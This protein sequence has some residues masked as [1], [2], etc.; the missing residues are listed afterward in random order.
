MGTFLQTK[1]HQNDISWLSPE[2]IL[3][4]Q[5]EWRWDQMATFLPRSSMLKPQRVATSDVRAGPCQCS[6][7]Q[8]CCWNML[9]ETS[10]TTWLKDIIYKS[11][12]R[13]YTFCHILSWYSAHSNDHRSHV[14]NN[15]EP[16][17]WLC[18]PLRWCILRSQ[19]RWDDGKGDGCSKRRAVAWAR[20]SVPRKMASP[21]ISSVAH[22][23][24]RIIDL[25]HLVPKSDIIG[26]IVVDWLE[27]LFA[28]I[29]RSFWPHFLVFWSYPWE[30]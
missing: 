26:G 16:W 1:I 23:C 22:G 8:R 2:A 12:C 6:R 30:S 17:T 5:P 13:L 14:G 27:K 20:S 3:Q 9:T 18:Y 11:Y 24:S 4:S 10:T 15:L 28:D 19:C 29:M 21:R 25:F 7:T